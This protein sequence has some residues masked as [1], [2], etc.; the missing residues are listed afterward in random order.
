MTRNGLSSYEQI[1]DSARPGARVTLAPGDL[2]TC[3]FV[4]TVTP[5][6]QGLV[7]RKH[8]LGGGGDFGFSVT[9]GGASLSASATTSLPEFAS[10]AEPADQLAQLPNGTPY[11]VEEELPESDGTG[12]WRLA[13]VTC[14]A[15]EQEVTG[16]GITV[17]APQACT[18]VNQ[19]TPKGR[20]TIDKITL[21][22]TGATRFQIAPDA[23]PQIVREQVATT[24]RVGVPARATGDSTTNIPLGVYSIQEST[25]SAEGA[26]GSWRVGSVICNG[27]PVPSI[28]GRVL[29]VLTETEP[30]LRCVFTNELRDDTVDPPAPE[31]PV[32]PFAPPGPV[33]G[34]PTGGVA[35]ALIAPDVTITKRARPR[36]VLL[37]ERV[38]YRI[39]VYNRGDGVAH[40]VTVAEPATPTTRDLRLRAK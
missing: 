8:S 6:A 10:L 17:T 30:A 15:A 11:R 2:M 32:G 27:V 23:D 9:G 35:G 31:P 13:R 19:F 20:L 33:P 40:G 25:A 26:R 5:P 12:T 29:V 22:G 16:G 28:A 7:L 21:G 18:F 24:R 39:V 38:R 1:G 34:A 14:G 37:G 36:R 3:T 4:N